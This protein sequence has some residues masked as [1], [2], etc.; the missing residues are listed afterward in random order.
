MKRFFNTRERLVPEALEGLL[1]SPAGKD[2]CRLDGYPD[3]KVIL[4]RDWERG[5]GKVAVISGGGS[6]HEPAHAGFVGRGMLTAAVCGSLFASPGVD[7][8]LAGILAVTGEAGCLLVVKNY[9]GD[10]LNFG[11]AAEQARAGAE[12]GD[13][14]RR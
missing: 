10:R 14:D 11:L 9:T 5:A 2:L 3:I 6:G 13:G 4:R 8:I 1:R 7:A 12:G